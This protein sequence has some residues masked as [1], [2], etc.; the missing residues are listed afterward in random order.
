MSSEPVL[1]RRLTRVFVTLAE[2]VPDTPA[3]TWAEAKF[4]RSHRRSVMSEVSAK[5]SILRR[6]S[7]RTLLSIG[8][9][10]GLAGV[11]TGIAAATGV[12]DNQGATKVFREFASIPAPASWG[13]L[14]AFNAKKER[15]QVTSPGPDG[16]TV[17]LWT[18]QETPTMSCTA[19]VESNPGEPLFP[20]KPE[21]GTAGGC[22]G[23]P[24]NAKAPAVL[25]PPPQNRSYG[26]DAG[27]WRSPKGILYYLVG[28]PTPAGSAHL[29]LHLANGTTDSIPTRNGW[30]VAVIGSDLWDRGYIGIFLNGEGQQMPGTEAG[31]L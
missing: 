10:I 23:S 9:A 2:A 24:P 14:P 8:I 5:Q 29:E 13:Y 4:D 6:R 16:T 28:G 18:Y 20:G 1:E 21:T 7:G 31:G 17:S 19:I 30:F 12:F 22:S 25:P 26:A 11:G 3:T 15:L 27:L